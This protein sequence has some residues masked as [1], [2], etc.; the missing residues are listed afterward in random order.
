MAQTP[1]SEWEPVGLRAVRPYLIVND[2]NEAIDFYRLV[3]EASELD[4][5]AHQQAVSLM[6]NS[7]SAKRLSRLASTQMPTG[8]SLTVYLGL[9][10][11]CMSQ[12]SVRQTPTWTRCRC[13]R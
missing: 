3:F 7:R 13:H 9:V 11:A 2:A 12:M 6:Q 1:K 10:S 8:E 4:D 5:T